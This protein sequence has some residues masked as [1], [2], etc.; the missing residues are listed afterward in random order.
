MQKKLN[1]LYHWFVVLPDRLYPFKREVEGE[2]VRGI[3]SYNAAFEEY[4][5]MYGLGHYGIKLDAYRQVFHLA[6]SV[7]FLTVAAYCSQY[8]FAS[9][10]ALPVFLG[11][12][13]LF[14]TFQEFFLHRRMYR[15]LWR[16]GI[17]DWLA[18]CVPMGIY[19]FTH[20]S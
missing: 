1:S 8:F 14:I 10:D 19:F 2:W 13:V 4:Q 3:R 7:L 12:A 11:I 5:K 15:Q 16:K 20:F 18:W 17:L 6:G 9:S